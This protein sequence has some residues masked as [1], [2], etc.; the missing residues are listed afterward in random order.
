MVRTL[1]STSNDSQKRESRVYAFQKNAG[2]AWE[3]IETARLSHDQDQFNR[4]NHVDILY[5][6]RGAMLIND[7]GLLIKSMLLG[8]GQNRQAE[9][10]RE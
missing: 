1:G 5:S 9:A 8:E 4:L 2:G 3:K 6:D 10:E 7:Q